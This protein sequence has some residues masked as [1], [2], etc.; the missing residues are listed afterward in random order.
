MTTISME[1]AKW[2]PAVQAKKDKVLTLF[3]LPHAGGDVINF[4]EWP[5]YLPPEVEVRCAA[6][7]GKYARSS[8][9]HL[10]SFNAAVAALEQTIRPY[11]GKPYALFGHSMGALLAFEL[12][13]R[14]RDS[15]RPP[16]GLFVSG[17]S[18]PHRFTSDRDSRRMTN[19]EILEFLRDTDG[20]PEEML[21]EE[22]AMLTV[23]PAVRHDLLLCDT[24]SYAHSQPLNCATSV[25]GGR[26]DD[27][28]AESLDAWREAVGPRCRVSWFD[29]GHMF[30]LTRPQEVTDAITSSLIGLARSAGA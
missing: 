2:F 21:V 3:C 10:P 29:G 13:H 22:G 4:W 14:L 11:L 26:E 9:P 12:A 15:E 28:D 18:A 24:Y 6:L 30:I 7:P 19:Q 27:F 20:I 8:E 5:R 1:P 16:L 17:M 23:I 25:F